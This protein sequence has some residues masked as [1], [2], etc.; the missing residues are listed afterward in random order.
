MRIIFTGG[1]TG[2]HLFP[3]I[4]VARELKKLTS[5]VIPS[6]QGEGSHSPDGK[7]LEM[8]FVGPKTLGD[9]IF[10]KEGIGTRAI[11]AGKLRRYFSGHN[12]LDFFR[13]F[14]GFLQSL[15]I[16]FAY[17]PN[18]IFSKGG[19]GS[20]PVVLVAWL[21]RIP[22]LVH[23]SDAIPGLSV[24]LTAKLCKRIAISF[25][26]AAEFF[27]AKKT[28]LLGNPV[29]AEIL[30]GSKEQGKTIFQLL[31][32]KPVILI[33]GGSQGAK[34]INDII[35]VTLVGLL[36]KCEI[37]HQ[38]GE[39]NFEEIKTLINKNQPAGYHL[40]PFLDEEQLRAA[41]AIADLV[42]SRAGAGSIFEIAACGK[43]SVLIPLPHSAQDHQKQNAFD[44]AK[45][46][47][48]LVVQQENLT[49]NFLKDR[50]FALLENPDLLAKMSIAAKSFARPDA[51][52]QI[53]QELLNIAKF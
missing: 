14:I 34:S 35:L 26:S 8:L 2:G 17:M 52:K 36:E 42:I 44:F 45:T 21:Y 10:E 47:A 48:T 5:R 18:V 29:R 27:P 50:V 30:T 33:L 12:F 40:Y 15:W 49:P 38:C 22:V 24:R 3:I 20:V 46:G 11:Q 28:A 4:A 39:E 7:P 23:E 13:V 31:G 9:K 43:P 1:G 32:Q 41:Y 51:D 53:A 6:T 37:I 16:V 19:F 25:P